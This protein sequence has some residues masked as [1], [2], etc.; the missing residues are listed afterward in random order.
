M[1]STSQL[2]LP[3][4]ACEWL[5]QGIRCTPCRSD[6]GAMKRN[7]QMLLSLAEAQ[8]LSEAGSIAA[9]LGALVIF[10]VLKLRCG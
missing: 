10:L 6:A 4:K 1:T 5:F 3:Q 7:Q 2:L 8:R 9:L